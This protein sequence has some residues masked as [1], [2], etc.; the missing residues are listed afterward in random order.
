MYKSYNAKISDVVSFVN[1]IIQ[2]SLINI[3]I[4][5]KKVKDSLINTNKHVLLT[6][7]IDSISLCMEKNII[8]WKEVATR[9]VSVADY[10]VL[11]KKAYKKPLTRQWVSK[12]CLDDRLPHLKLSG[13]HYIILDENGKIP[14]IAAP[15][16]KRGR[17]IEADKRFKKEDKKAAK[18]KDKKGGFKAIT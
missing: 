17:P 13:V 7:E 1:S 12:M 11:Y 2:Y 18:K 15:A 16:G 6:C 10:A 14:P 9:L 5:D 8:D 4:F 3:I